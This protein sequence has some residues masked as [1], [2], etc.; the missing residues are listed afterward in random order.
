MRQAME[1]SGISSK[2][3]VVNTAISE[4]VARRTRRDLKELRGKIAFA[5]G[6]DY[7]AAREE[8]KQ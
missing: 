6:H 8:R 3:D 1:V 5:D 2:K 7:K 4:F